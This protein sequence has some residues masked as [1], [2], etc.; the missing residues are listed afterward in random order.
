MSEYREFRIYNAYCIQYTD[1]VSLEEND[2]LASAMDGKPIRRQYNV[3]EH[4]A[5]LAEKEAKER[6]VNYVLSNLR[7]CL[8]SLSDDQ[9]RGRIKRVIEQ[10]GA[11][12]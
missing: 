8:D 5:Y 11:E 2:G 1:G 12:K 9:V 6:A 10:L 7:D 4:Q 3:I